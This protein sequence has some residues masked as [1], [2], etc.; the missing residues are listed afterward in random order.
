MAWFL[1]SWT[2]SPW[3]PECPWTSA[4]PVLSALWTSLCFSL[5]FLIQVHAP[6]LKKD[7]HKHPTDWTELAQSC[8][9]PVR[10]PAWYVYQWDCRLN[11]SSK[12]MINVPTPFNKMTWQPNLYSGSSLYLTYSLHR[13]AV[14]LCPREPC[15]LSLCIPWMWQHIPDGHKISWICERLPIKLLMWKS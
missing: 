1:L 8:F 6:L 5:L 13:E 7:C 12:W 15:S 4:F 14:C 9:N 2:G 10:L 3:T 11:T